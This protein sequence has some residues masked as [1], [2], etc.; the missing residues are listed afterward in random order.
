MRDDLYLCHL[1]G[2]F[3]EQPGVLSVREPAPETRQEISVLRHVGGVGVSAVAETEFVLGAL[4]ACWVCVDPS[5][6]F[7][8]GPQ[9]EHGDAVRGE[10]GQREADELTGNTRGVVGDQVP[11]GIV[12]EAAFEAIAAFRVVN[13]A[14]IPDIERLDG[15]R[16]EVGERPASKNA[17]VGRLHIL[18]I[19]LVEVLPVVVWDCVAVRCRR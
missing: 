13:R 3:W 6:V 12:G 1:A 10:V 11:I 14:R 16:R 9:I 8:G 2:L 17:L 5:C 7:V 19:S 18:A 15:A 4:G